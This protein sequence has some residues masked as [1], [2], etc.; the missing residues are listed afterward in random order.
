MN[1][2]LSERERREELRQANQKLRASAAQIEKLAMN[3]E[4]SRIA[5][6]IHDS[7]GHALTGLN[8]QL[9]GTLKLWDAHPTKARAFVT[10]AKEMGSTALNETRQAVTTLRQTPRVQQDLAIAIA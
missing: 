1:A 2:L 3:Q 4:R 7:L 9:E 10:Q 6:E 8:I 5:R